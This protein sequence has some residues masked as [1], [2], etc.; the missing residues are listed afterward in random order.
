M[1]LLMH[2][3][4][5]RS[6][7]RSWRSL[8]AVGALSLGCG[9]ILTGTDPGPPIAQLHGTVS[10][11][12]AAPM[13]APYVE[14]LWAFPLLTQ[15]GATPL[16]VDI[17]SG[18]ALVPI[19]SDFPS[20]FTL[21]LYEPPPEAL[22]GTADLGEATPGGGEDPE[23]FRFAMATLVVFDDVNRDGDFNLVDADGKPTSVYAFTDE[24][25]APDVLRGWLSH[26]AVIFVAHLPASMDAAL[27]QHFANPEALKPGF[28]TIT[29]CHVPGSASDTRLQVI[30]ADAALSLHL[31]E[32]TYEAVAES[33]PLWFDDVLALPECVP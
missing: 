21:D 4:R 22:I 9:G 2:S 19:R 13:G 7:H 26:G 14:L 10:E 6:M 3:P 8:V 30:P 31:V 23:G 12:T 11:A 28:Q 33:Q 20:G 15:G 29:R 5:E 24:T 32:P 16:P 18:H 27:A 1:V 25:F 17:Q